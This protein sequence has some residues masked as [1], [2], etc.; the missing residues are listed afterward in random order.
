MGGSLGTR[1]ISTM[2]LVDQLSECNTWFPPPTH[3]NLSCWCWPLT[4]ARTISGGLSPTHSVWGGDLPPHRGTLLG[5]V[6]GRLHVSSQKTHYRRSSAGKVLLSLGE[7]SELHCQLYSSLSLAV[8][9]N[10]RSGCHLFARLGQG[11]WGRVVLAPWATAGWARTVKLAT[12][13]QTRVPTAAGRLQHLVYIIA[14]RFQS[15]GWIL[16]ATASCWCKMIPPSG[17]QL[18]QHHLH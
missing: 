8:P 7:V 14:G 6:R 10:D 2:V 3:L 17:M 5:G 12:I 18:L 13:M 15:S 1:V 16:S 4:A 9:Q 11:R